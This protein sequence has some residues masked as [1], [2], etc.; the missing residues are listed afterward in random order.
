MKQLNR[1]QTSASSKD[2][3]KIINE[4]KD[5][6]EI[7]N[8]TIIESAERMSDLSGSI[9]IID[10][11]ISGVQEPI[12]EIN[13]EIDTLH[14]PNNIPLQS[15]EKIETSTGEQK[16]AGHESGKPQQILPA[17]QVSL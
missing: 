13:N 11:E 4:T 1:I 15:S 3:E 8:S 5:I 7:N 14:V 17:L 2:I 9:K 10:Y 16:V 12:R 6:I